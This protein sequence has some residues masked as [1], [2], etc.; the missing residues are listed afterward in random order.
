MKKIYIYT[1]YF[2]II[3]KSLG[4]VVPS[5]PTIKLTKLDIGDQ[6]DSIV[7]V[8]GTILKMRPSSEFQ[9]IPFLKYSI[10]DK[11]VWNNGQGGIFENTSFGDKALFSNTTGTYNTVYGYS[12]LS[13]NTTGS[14]VSAFGYNAGKYLADGITLNEESN[15]C[16]YLG[17]NPRSFEANTF[18]ENVIGANAIGHGS[19]TMTFGNPDITGNYFT[20]DM[21]AGSYV[22]NGYTG[23]RILLDDGNLIEPNTTT[24]KLFLSSTGDGMSGNTPVWS[25]LTESYVPYTGATSDLNMD[26][27]TITASGVTVTG[28]T[29]SKLLSTDGANNL[30]SLSTV[31]YPD[32]TE[33]SYVKGVTSSVQNQI[34]SKSPIN[35]PIFTGIPEAPTATAGTNNTQIATTAFVTTATSSVA[36]PDASTTLKGKVQ[37]AGDLTGTAAAPVIANGAISLSGTKVTGIL[38]VSNGGTG[39]TSSTGTGSVVLSTSPSLTTPTIGVATGTSLQL[40][41]LNASQLVATD[42]SKNLTSLDVATYPSLTELSYVKGATSSIQTQL[43]GKTTL[44]AVNAQNLSVFAPTTSA[45]LAGVVTNETG[46]GSLVFANTP[47]LVT[48]NI[49]AAT[50]TSLNVTGNIQNTGGGIFAFGT[51]GSIVTQGITV[52]SARVLGVNNQDNTSG[53]SSSVVR[54]QVGGSA[55]GDPTFE[56]NISSATTYTKRLDNSDSDK[57]VEAFDALGTTPFRITTTGGA[58]TMPLQPSFSAYKSANTTNVTGDGTAYTVICN[59]E[60]YDQGANYNNATGVFTAP[61]T[62]KYMF[63]ITVQ[64]S[65]VGGTYAT[66]SLFTTSKN[67]TLSNLNTN[68]KD[69]T[70]VMTLSGVVIADMTAGDTATMVVTVSGGAKTTGVFGAGS[71]AT[72]FQGY[73]LH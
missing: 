5:Y 23:K 28:L 49:G 22:V 19:N 12:A 38:P 42:A 43:D 48:P 70:N 46:T 54:S 35:N 34:D 11:T 45:Q 39:V 60:I 29:V 71:P 37:L 3:L 15:S 4:Q 40:S 18:N 10:T 55:A 25:S 59:S 65:A 73:L 8:D 72:F 69:P 14:G 7:V 50:G 41:G 2:S 62:G 67:Y 66:L 57:L 52:S 9:S 17:I 64:L 26:I 68:I 47:T 16:L 44:A 56:L 51:T 30:T 58:T 53:T 31:T 6:H 1:F 27:H 36:T 20:G 61:V 33:I 63:N 13:G 24:E 32:L 21:F